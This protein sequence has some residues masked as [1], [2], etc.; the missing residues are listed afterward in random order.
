MA[1]SNWQS[2]NQEQSQNLIYT[3]NQAKT[4]LLQLVEEAI[5]GKEV[6]IARGNVP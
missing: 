1:I 5:A 3:I 4:M 6:I 2:Q